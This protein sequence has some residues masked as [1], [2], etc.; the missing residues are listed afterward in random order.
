[1]RQELV[2][3]QPREQ[4]GEFAEPLQLVVTEIAK[5]PQG[6]FMKLMKSPKLTEADRRLFMRL[7]ET[8]MTP[9]MRAILLGRSGLARRVME[10]MGLDESAFQTKKARLKI[11][12]TTEMRVKS[13]V[14]REIDAQGWIDIKKEWKKQA[15]WEINS[16]LKRTGNSETAVKSAK[17]MLKDIADWCVGSVECLRDAMITDWQGAWTIN[18]EGREVDADGDKFYSRGKVGTDV[19]KNK[20]PLLTIKDTTKTASD[21]G[22]EYDEVRTYNLVIGE[23]GQAILLDGGGGGYEKWTIPMRTLYGFFPLMGL[24]IPTC[25]KQGR[26]GMMKLEIDWKEMPL[27]RSY[28]SLTAK[29]KEEIQEKLRSEYAPKLTAFIGIARSKL[30]EIVEEAIKGRVKYTDDRGPRGSK[31]FYGRVWEPEK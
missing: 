10:I 18:Q 20:T 15:T 19:W 17:D 14:A 27:V 16:G 24:P 11:A 13:E 23:K 30:D 7:K 6:A 2:A 8:K 28:K 9:K 4:T 22:Q 1:L 21:T 3:E 29:A 25:K 31:W 12:D 5:Q 26:A